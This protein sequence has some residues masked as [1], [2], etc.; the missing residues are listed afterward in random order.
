MDSDYGIDN[1]K[2][3]RLLKEYLLEQRRDQFARGLVKRLLAYSLGRSIELADRAMVDQLTDQFA[4][5]GYRLSPLIV[6][7]VQSETFQQK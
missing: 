4:E 2:E 5:S 3:Y 7:I 1:Q 6:A